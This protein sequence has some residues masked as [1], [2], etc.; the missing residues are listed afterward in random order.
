MQISTVVM[1]STLPQ[2]VCERIR[3]RLTRGVAQ[4]LA[5]P[6]AWNQAPV[7]ITKLPNGLKVATQETAGG[8]SST[9]L[10]IDAGVR[11]EDASTVGA[12]RVIEKLA[13]TGTAKRDRSQLEREVELMGAEL[14]VDAGREQTK[15]IV[16]GGD[17]KQNV[18]ILADVVTSPGL[19]HYDTERDAIVRSLATGDAPTRAVIADRLHQCAF[20]DCSLGSTVIGPFDGIEHLSQEQLASYVDSNYTAD[21]MVLVATGPVKHAEVVGLATDA[22]GGLK[23]SEW[24]DS[25]Q[26]PY[27]CG[28]ELLYK[29][30]DG[31]NGLHFRRIRECALEECGCGHF[32]GNAAHHRQ[33]QE[34][35]GIG[36]GND[37]R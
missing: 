11:S 23:S 5:N 10:F 1:I 34:E 25:W 3:P 8:V 36:A 33:L 28:A 18:N 20:R 6:A 37:F 35:R 13:F 2:R 12:T 7:Q 17:V 31:S 4:A 30:R 21:K 24:T 15:F 22:L 14:S 16:A 9:G 19:G 29:R 26:K 32:H 27:F